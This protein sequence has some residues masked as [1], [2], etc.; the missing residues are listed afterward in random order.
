MIRIPCEG[1]PHIRGEPE[2]FC[3][4]RSGATPCPSSTQKTEARYVNA[5][6]R[7]LLCVSI[8]SSGVR[9][10]VRGAS[11]DKKSKTCLST[12]VFNA[13][14]R[15]HANEQARETD[16]EI[17]LLSLSVEPDIQAASSTAAEV[18][19]LF[20]T[21]NPPNHHLAS[22]TVPEIATTI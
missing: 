22:D 18:S 14:M 13:R 16:T 3:E 20:G 8:S 7:Q 11:C 21:A 17:V 2:L 4:N 9:E 6:G 10:G 19:V 15:S 1:S 12:V 5:F